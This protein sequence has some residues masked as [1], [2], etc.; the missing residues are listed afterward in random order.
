MKEQV[1]T[2][3][4][5]GLSVMMGVAGQTAIKL[6][7][8]HP[9]STGLVE[10]GPMGVFV[11]MIRWPLVLLGLLM[12]GVDALA[13][14]VVLSRVDLSNAY[15]FLALNFVLITIVSRV[16]F[17]ETIPGVRWLGTLVICVGI[18]LVGWSATSG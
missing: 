11:M 6:G 5:I 7:V 3:W 12:Y 9:E 1:S 10:S 18:V 17:S 4:L 16:I 2:L 13:W 8:N 14:I 15:P